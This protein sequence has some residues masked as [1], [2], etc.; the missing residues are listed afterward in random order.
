C[1]E[2]GPNQPKYPLLSAIK[3]TFSKRSAGL[4]KKANELAILCD[5]E[6]VVNISSNIDK[7]F[8]FS[9]S[10]MLITRIIDYEL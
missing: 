10:R 9:N 6:V 2:R 4:L 8:K 1:D 7:L 3:V 5:D